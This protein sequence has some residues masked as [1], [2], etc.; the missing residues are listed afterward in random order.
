MSE[1]IVVENNSGGGSVG[2][3][4]CILVVWLLFFGGCGRINKIMDLKIAEM[5][6]NQ[7]AEVEVGK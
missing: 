5:E 3:F 2:C 7:P 6:R 4:F 1:E